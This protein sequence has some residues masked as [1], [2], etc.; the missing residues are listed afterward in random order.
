MAFT[1][2]PAIT[3]KELLEAGDNQ[4]STCRFWYAPQIECR[5]RA[6]TFVAEGEMGGFPKTFGDTGCGEFEL[7]QEE[8]AKRYEYLDSCRAEAIRDFRKMERGGI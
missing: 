2:A 3:D 1:I 6:P 8:R 4:C 5:R 7:S